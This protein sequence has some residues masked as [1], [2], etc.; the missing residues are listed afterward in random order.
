MN[1]PGPWIAGSPSG[2]NPENA[3]TVYSEI[4]GVWTSIGMAWNYRDARLIAAAPDLLEAAE[5]VLNG[6]PIGHIDC[7]DGHCNYVQNADGS[8]GNE[9]CEGPEVRR[10]HAAIAKARGEA[11]A[12]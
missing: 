10:L 12:S 3:L 6:F 9:V 4:D 8:P 2:G 1:T 7:P 5:A 11:V